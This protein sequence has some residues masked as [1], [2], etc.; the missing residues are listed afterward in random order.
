MR[1]NNN[2]N[3]RHQ[4]AEIDEQPDQQRHAA[5]AAAASARPASPEPEDIHASSSKAK[6]RTAAD[7]YGRLQWDRDA[8]AYEED[9]VHVRGREP[10]SDYYIGYMDRIT[11]L[12]EMAL[13]EFQPFPVGEIPWHRVWYFRNSTHIVWDR[14]ARLDFVFM[15]GDTPAYVNAHHER[16]GILTATSRFADISLIGSAKD[17]EYLHQ[18]E[19][20]KTR[21]DHSCLSK[22][23]PKNRRAL[24]FQQ[25]RLD[26]LDAAQAEHRQA[27]RLQYFAEQA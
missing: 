10:E 9:G 5:A 16:D 11:G 19:V 8:E 22:F 18:C 7:I 13:S 15:S 25:H 21:P 23:N 4:A 26:A 17:V 14:I 12:C 24:V 1:R 20:S 27:M 2:N 6:L 3:Q